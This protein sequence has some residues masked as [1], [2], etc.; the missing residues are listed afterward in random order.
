MYTPREELRSLTI[1]ELVAEVDN[2]EKEHEEIIEVLETSHS[3]LQSFT[4]ELEESIA[5]IKCVILTLLELKFYGMSYG[6]LED[7]AVWRRLKELEEKLS[8]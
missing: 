3:E 8:G 4:D 5:E 1:E 2:I 7:E 6:R